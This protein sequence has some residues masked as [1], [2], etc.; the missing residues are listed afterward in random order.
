MQDKHS[1]KMEESLPAA[2]DRGRREFM[3]KTVYATCAT[4][5]ISALMVN[6]AEAMTGS[7][8]CH[9]L[10]DWTGWDLPCEDWD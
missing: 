9:R 7:E 3:R 8:F 6:K 2:V 1:E 4:P 10:E 5:V